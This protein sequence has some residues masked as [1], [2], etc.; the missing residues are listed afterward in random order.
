MPINMKKKKKKNTESSIN[1]IERPPAF[2]L[3]VLR[4]TTVDHL[5]EFLFRHVRQEGLRDINITA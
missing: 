2:R 5:Q 4:V 3:G 1:R